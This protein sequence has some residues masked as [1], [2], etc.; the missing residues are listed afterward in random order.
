MP[1]TPRLLD[2]VRALTRL[3]HYSI[4][5][6]RAHCD[7]MKRYVFFHRTASRDDLRGGETK[8]A[9]VSGTP[10]RERARL[11]IGSEP[12]HEC[13]G[14]PLEKGVEGPIGGAHRRC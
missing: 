7:W 6:E 3:H 9:G 2:E 12:A 5:V 10:R 14:L 1:R 8:N 11:S 4:H 13:A